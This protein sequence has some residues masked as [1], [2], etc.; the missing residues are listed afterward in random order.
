MA[1]KLQ[2]LAVVV[3]YGCALPACVQQ[4]IQ[5]ERRTDVSSRYDRPA[6]SF[7]YVGMPEQHLVELMGE[8]G[9]VKRQG[10]REIWY[11][12]FG[13]VVLQNDHVTF[14]YPPRPDAGSNAFPRKQGR[15]HQR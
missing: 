12:G 7:I 3:C 13:L 8:P 10:D 4:R 6:D 14:R 9:E 15:P 5:P 1:N 2:I 11:Y